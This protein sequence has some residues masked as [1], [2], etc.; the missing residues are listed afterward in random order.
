MAP[1]NRPQPIKEM[2]RKSHDPNGLATGAPFIDPPDPV[3]GS[4]QE[5]AEYRAAL[6]RSGLPGLE[7]FITQADKIIEGLL[8]LRTF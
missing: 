1:S 2:G 8:R 6:R 5:W 3:F 7:P 4:L